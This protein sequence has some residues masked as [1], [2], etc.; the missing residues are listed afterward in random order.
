MMGDINLVPEVLREFVLKNI[1]FKK[2]Y[3]MPTLGVGITDNGIEMQYNP[4]FYNNLNN[5]QKRVI[6]LHELAH[7]I[8]GDILKKFEDRLT[9]NI[10]FDSVVN[11]YFKESDREIVRKLNGVIYEDL[12]EKYDLPERLGGISEFEIYSKIKES[13]DFQL[14]DVILVPTNNPVAK[15][16]ALAE[17]QKIRK[18]L[19]EAGID[20]LEKEFHDLLGSNDLVVESSGQIKA[21]LPKRTIVAIDRI[22]SICQKQGNIYKH[23]R[24]YRRE[25]LYEGLRGLTRKRVGKMFLGVDVSGSVANY[26]PVFLGIGKQ[27]VMKKYIVEFGS[28]S[29]GFTLYKYLPRNENQIKGVGGGTE[30][31]QMMSYLQKQDM[32]LAIV[33]TDGE[34]W[35]WK[36]ELSERLPFPV[37]W[38]LVGDRK[39]KVPGKDIII[40]ID[41]VVRTEGE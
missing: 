33:I 39:F 17:I 23:T 18:R 1:S 3:D 16:K 25:G 32:D 2:N 20:E 41:D 37:V 36:P 29:S 26:I 9:W 35:D 40:N 30:I 12:R 21:K 13:N 28:F 6:W 34:I 4:D 19:S 22:M 11:Q 14:F 31:R 38:L 24:N 15:T 7:V 5:E 27:L 8:R 10:V